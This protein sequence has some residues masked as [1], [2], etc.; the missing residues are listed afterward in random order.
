MTDVKKLRKLAEMATPGPWELMIYES[1]TVYVGMKN[2]DAPKGEYDRGYLGAHI[3]LYNVTDFSQ[4]EEDLQRERYHNG[5]FIA[6]AN[7]QAVIELLDRLERYEKA[8]EM[9]RER[10]EEFYVREIEKWQ[11]AWMNVTGTTEEDSKNYR[12]RS[13]G[14]DANMRYDLARRLVGVQRIEGEK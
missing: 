14:I 11:F 9:I 12:E 10:D 6:T 4:S 1:G 3:T 13:R 8:L 5:E 7:P 2:A